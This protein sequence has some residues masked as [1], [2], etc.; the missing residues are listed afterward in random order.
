MPE[1]ILYIIFFPVHLILFLMPEYYHG[2][3]G[4]KM[5]ACLFTKVVIII[6]LLYL[7]D[8]FGINFSRGVKLNP[9]ITGFLFCSIGMNFHFVIYN[10]KVNLNLLS[11]LKRINNLNSYKPF[12]NFQHLDKVYVLGYPHYSGKE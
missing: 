4:K 10:L 7:I 5:A 2:A 1:R 8:E 6:L 3:S 11:L 12:F 9:S